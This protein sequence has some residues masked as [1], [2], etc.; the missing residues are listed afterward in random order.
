MIPTQAA[1][2]AD[3]CKAH[4]LL[5]KYNGDFAEFFAIQK[6]QLQQRSREAA[7]GRQNRLA[8]D[9]EKVSVE[10][11]LDARCR[12][13]QAE[14]DKA[15]NNSNPE[16]KARCCTA[17]AARYPTIV[18]R[19]ELE[20]ELHCTESRLRAGRRASCWS[21]RTRTPRLRRTPRREEKEKRTELENRT[22]CKN[23]FQ[24]RKA[25]AE[26]GKD[27]ATKMLEAELQ[28]LGP[29]ACLGCRKPL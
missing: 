25:A 17:R 19:L 22:T 27:E 1:W 26:A 16:M 13:L 24:Q 8:R 9:F 14:M 2:D 4:V 10:T 12:Q 7:V 28:A 5:K 23:V 21:R 11:D 29:K 15:I 20:R 18:L 3:R 6:Q